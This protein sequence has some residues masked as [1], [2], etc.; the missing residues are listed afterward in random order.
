VNADDDNGSPVYKEIPQ[1]RDF[2]VTNLPKDDPEL[3]LVTLQVHP[4]IS[5]M[6]LV[7]TISVSDSGPD[8]LG[9]ILLWEDPR[10]VSPAQS[11]YQVDQFG[12]VLWVEGT[13]PSAMERDLII[14][15]NYNLALPSRPPRHVAGSDRLAVTVTPVIDHFTNTVG[16]VQFF[17]TQNLGP[18]NLPGDFN[19]VGGMV[20]GDPMSLV[21]QNVTW[22]TIRA[23]AKFEASLLARG[24]PGD[25]LYIQNQ[26]GVENGGQTTQGVGVTVETNSGGQ[27]LYAVSPNP[28][29]SFPLLDTQA[30]AL[31]PDYP[32]ASDSGGDTDPRIIRAYD[33]PYFTT[34][35]DWDW[36]KSVQIDFEYDFRMYLVWRYPA[37]DPQGSILYTLAQIDWQVYFR[38]DRNANN[39]GLGVN[40]VLGCGVGTGDYVVSHENPKVRPPLVNGNFYWELIT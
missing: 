34:S 20:A 24:M 5:G 13:E 23:G 1:L 37:R 9:N 2:H 30:P 31:T 25:P 14:T 16:T 32:L 12:Q 26:L 38:A 22:D 27:Q 40:E 11:T 3:M 6:V 17:N 28:G 18:A 36:Q 39:P 19:G 33:F 4:Y 29:L 35:A 15:V 8:S 7:A 21:G 10:K